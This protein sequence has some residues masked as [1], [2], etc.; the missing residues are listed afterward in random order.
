MLLVY[1]MNLS[2]YG[3][4]LMDNT[5]EFSFTIP[6]YWSDQDFTVYFI[7]AADDSYGNI[8]YDAT[9]QPIVV[10]YIDGIETEQY[11]INDFGQSASITIDLVSPSV[12]VTALN[13]GEVFEPGD[14][15]TITWEASDAI[16]LAAM[17]ITI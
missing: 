3:V 10:D 6:S 15:A 1:Q 7:V 13:N 5:G 14:I 4:Q 17:P 2:P 12:T 8:G 16:S 11:A 9:N